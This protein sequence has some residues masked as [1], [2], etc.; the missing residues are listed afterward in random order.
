[1]EI[2]LKDKEPLCPHCGKNPYQCWECKFE[3]RGDE[4]LCSVCNFFN[5][6]QCQLCSPNCLLP[7]ILDHINGWTDH[8]KIVE[9]VFEKR[10][11]AEK[12]F[13][14]SRK[15][16]ISYAK[17]RNRFTFFK[18]KGE[19]FKNEND[20]KIYHE[21]FESVLTTGGAKSWTITDIR[22]D[23]SYGR[24]F[25]DILNFC[26]CM[27]KVEKKKEKI[28]TKEFDVFSKSKKTPCEYLKTR[29][30]LSMQCK[31]CDKV[32][33]YGTIKCDECKYRNGKKKGEYYNLKL[34]KSTTEMCQLPRREFKKEE[35]VKNG[36]K[37][38][39]VS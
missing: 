19:G 6:P 14:P 38:I 23:G 35:D 32:F 1:L 37:C 34:R 24:E 30:I 13:C 10:G 4:K 5:C 9:Y 15:V 22:E 7:E 18:L 17:T 16:S 36:D 27:G 21:R 28:G 33:D 8:R 2:N 20:A 26:T 12:M 25:R 11:G 39:S 3:I 31:I 29:N